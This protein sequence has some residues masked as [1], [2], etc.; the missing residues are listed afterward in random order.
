M[1]KGL[2]YASFTK[3]VCMLMIVI[4]LNGWCSMC[5]LEYCIG[6]G[7]M[8]RQHLGGNFILV[9]KFHLVFDLCKKRKNT[10]NLAKLYIA[11]AFSAL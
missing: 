10:P 4:F 1:M 9:S 2:F 6:N 11:R 5:V 7:G 8:K 3:I